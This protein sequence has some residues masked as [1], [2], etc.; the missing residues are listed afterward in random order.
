MAAAGRWAT[1]TYD[2]ETLDYSGVVQQPESVLRD[3]YVP[4]VGT[5]K[6]VELDSSALPHAPL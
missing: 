4:F 1:T 6:A 3:P 5:P 2:A